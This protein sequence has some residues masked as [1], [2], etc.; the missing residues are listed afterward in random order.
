MKTETKYFGII[1]TVAIIAAVLSVCLV[2]SGCVT[3]Y[4]QTNVL[5]IEPVVILEIEK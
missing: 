5:V 3:V 1:I 2:M 4:D